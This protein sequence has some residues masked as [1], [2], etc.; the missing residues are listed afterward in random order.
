M[1]VSFLDLKGL[2]LSIKPDVDRAIQE[3]VSNC[4]FILGPSVNSFEEEF[5]KYCGAK[6]AVGVNSG[7]A[8]LHLAFT[9]LGV[10]EGDEVITVPNTF[11]ATASAIVHA[12]AKP[13]FVDVDEETYNMDVNLIE[14][15]I[16]PRTKAIVPV[17]LYGNP[18]NMIKIKEI[19]D[20]HNLLVIED[21]CQAHGAMHNG[22]KVGA[23][24][25][26]IAFSFYP[27]KNL[28]AFGEAGA[29]V[30][31]NA[32]VADKVK[33]LRA[34]GE[35]PKNT[36]NVVGYNFR[37]GGVQGAILG[38]KLKYLDE[39]NE[40]RRNNAELYS[41]LLKYNVIIP[42]VP[43]ENLTSMHL[44]VIR[45]QRREALREF[46]ASKGVDTGVHYEKPI[47]LQKAFSDLGYKEGDFPVA[48]RVMKE[49]VSLPMCPMLSEEQIRYVCEC[50]K[51][52]DRLQ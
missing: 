12:G 46:L 20:K 3:M 52:F 15:K 35:S 27:G 36:H 22:M 18:C 9:A 23:F 28:G 7:T 21:A 25:D 45:H 31:N 13:V 48:E 5:A 50:V 49:I 33:L 26:A 40:K 47:H 44:Y 42:K 14:S 17:H 1:R 19:A 32:E 29:V 16:T 2:Y 39:W 11:F 41:S 51:E 10:G 30:T 34:H 38:A 43:E 6:Y 4:S 8:A 24:S 37:M